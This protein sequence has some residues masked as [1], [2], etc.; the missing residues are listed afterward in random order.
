MSLSP[1]FTDR[2]SHLREDG[3]WIDAQLSASA[4][5]FIVIYKSAV[6]CHD[7]DPTRVCFLSPDAVSARSSM[8]TFLG[9]VDGVSYFALPIQNDAEAE[10]LCQTYQ[11][12]FQDYTS[13]SPMLES[14]YRDLVALA[15]FTNYWHQR[16]QHCG[17][18][19]APTKIECA[20]HTHTCTS[21]SCAQ[22]YFPSMDPAVIVL[23]EYEDRC[24]LG[25]QKHW[26]EGMFSTLAGFVEP[27]ETIE[28]A[29]AR[30]V[31]EEAGIA[32]EA[33]RYQS[34]QAWLFPN[35]LMLGFTAQATSL[36]LNIDHNEIETAA[37]FTREQVKADRQM[38]P[39]KNSISYALIQDWLNRGICECY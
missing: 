39:S 26:R 9:R 36:E 35:S 8:S 33:I 32:V 21:P 37:W 14:A 16:H 10:R 5:R 22:Q 17:A 23:I 6:L 30:E 28:A 20:G 7:E 2:A 3:A 12:N 4:T 27:G 34:S 15:C 25:R 13:R 24:L 18:C 19:G 1:Y 31:H 11:A 29:V 38:L